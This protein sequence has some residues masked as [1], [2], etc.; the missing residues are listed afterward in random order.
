MLFQRNY[1][2]VID[3]NGKP[4][5][6]TP[7]NQARVSASVNQP[8]NLKVQLSSNVTASSGCRV[9]KHDANLMKLRMRLHGSKVLRSSAA[10]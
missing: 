7:K 3:A 8:L 2:V 9:E 1:D 5:G 10:P 6:V 4:H